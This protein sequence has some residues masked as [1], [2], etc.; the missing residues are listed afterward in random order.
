[1]SW[2]DKKKLLTGPFRIMVKVVGR[3]PHGLLSK[4][5]SYRYKISPIMHHVRVAAEATRRIQIAFTPIT[6]NESTHEKKM[7]S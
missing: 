5:T 6:L 2:I 7:V 3:S 1:M 4:D